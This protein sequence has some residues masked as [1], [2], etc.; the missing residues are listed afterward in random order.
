MHAF[1]PAGAGRRARRT[2]LAAAV[3]AGALATSALATPGGAPTCFG[4]SG[5]DV[6]GTRDSDVLVGT[7]GPDRIYGGGGADRIYGLGGDDLLCGG[8]GSDI[9]DGAGGTDRIDGAYHPP[10]PRYSRFTAS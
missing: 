4:E 8:A 9:V 3:T 7:P 10:P 6:V 2:L 5:F 1:T